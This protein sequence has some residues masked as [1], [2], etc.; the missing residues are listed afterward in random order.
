MIQFPC[1]NF[2]ESYRVLF[3]EIKLAI[4]K[5]RNRIKFNGNYRFDIVKAM[6]ITSIVEW[7][8]ADISYEDP[9][10]PLIL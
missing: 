5:I 9:N 4:K 3:E 6:I 1:K 10:K 7:L 2:N 8:F